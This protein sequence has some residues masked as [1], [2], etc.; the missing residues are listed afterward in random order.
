VLNPVQVREILSAVRSFYSWIVL[1]LGRLTS[2]SGALLGGTD[3]LYLFTTTQLPALYEAKRVVDALKEIAFEMDRLRLIITE[4]GNSPTIDHN[5]LDRAFGIRV[6]LRLS[7]AGHEL[8]EA[9]TAGKLP[10][11]NGAYR[12]QIA[13][14]ARRIA[15]L[16]PEEA[17]KRL[18]PRLFA[19]QAVPR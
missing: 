6:D 17:S 2:F 9:H 14:L 11:K 10:D 15:G 16:P 1:D 5:D 8:Q 12:R 4:T 13:I 19:K 18:L 7:D 3:E